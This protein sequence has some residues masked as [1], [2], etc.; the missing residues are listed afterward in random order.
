MRERSYT[1]FQ[2][3]SLCPRK[4]VLSRKYEPKVKALALSEGG[5]FHRALAALATTGTWADEFARAEKECTEKATAGGS[6]PEFLEKLNAKLAAARAMM[7]VYSSEIFIHDSNQY[8]FLKTESDFRVRI[9]RGLYLKGI[10]D[11]VWR[12]KKTGTRYIVEHKYKAEHHEELMPLDLQ[13]SLYTLA[14]I[15]EYGTALPTLYNV[16]KKPLHRFK[17]GES[18]PDFTLRVNEK[19]MEDQKGFQYGPEF[20]SKFFIRRAYT[21]GRS[22]LAVVVDQIKEVARRMNQVWRHPENAYRNVGE[23]CVY[24]CPFTKICS[25]EDEFIVG[26]FYDRINKEEQ[27]VKPV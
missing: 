9:A 14:L 16:I 5:V 4:W 11:G 2:S 21:R 6:K 15:G 7:L 22:E 10:V 12:D 3:F 1:Q 17:S 8:D 20:E 23:H 25:E 24:G 18:Y 13:V 26:Q 27:V 19:V